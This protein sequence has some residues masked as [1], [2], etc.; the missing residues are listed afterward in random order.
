V[1]E[2]LDMDPLMLAI[3][4]DDFSEP[5]RLN[6][7]RKTMKTHIYN[8]KKSLPEPCRGVR[9]AGHSAISEL[10]VYHL[11]LLEL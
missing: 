1:L 11:V 5:E 7:H 3:N 9:L 6:E 2:P 10:T 4:V 8:T